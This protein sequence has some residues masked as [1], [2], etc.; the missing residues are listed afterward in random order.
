MECATRTT[1]TML[2]Q[3]TTVAPDRNKR[4]H[5]LVTGKYGSISWITSKQKHRQQSVTP[6]YTF[7]QRQV[8][9]A[10]HHVV[11]GNARVSLANRGS[12]RSFMLPQNRWKKSCQSASLADKRCFFCSSVF[13]EISL[14]HTTPTPHLGSPIWPFH[15]K[16][17]SYP[18]QHGGPA[19]KQFPQEISGLAFENPLHFLETAGC[20]QDTFIMAPVRL[21]SLSLSPPTSLPARLSEN[22]CSAF[23]SNKVLQS[24]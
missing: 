2:T 21:A 11:L 5:L 18:E 4:A 6:C 24:I 16:C 23:N 8:C 15:S 9:E 10:R 17:Y 14:C 12:S 3:N 7:L 19:Q 22:T 20:G 1:S 13:P